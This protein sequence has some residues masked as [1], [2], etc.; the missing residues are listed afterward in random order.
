MLTVSEVA[1]LF[2]SSGSTILLETRRDARDGASR[3]A[4]PSS[5]ALMLTQ[6]N[7]AASRLRAQLGMRKETQGIDAYVAKTGNVVHHRNDETVAVKMR[8]R[9]DVEVT[10]RGRPDGICTSIGAIVEHKYRPCGLLERVPFYEQVQ[11]HLYMKMFGL[12]LAHLVETFNMHMR[13]HEIEFDANTWERI[14]SVLVQKVGASDF[15]VSQKDAIPWKTYFPCAPSTARSERP[16]LA[17]Q[18]SSSRRPT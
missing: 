8:I 18:T 17:E 13:V 3:R 11:C 4:S 5:R 6:S 7:G 10:V 16:R 14:C 2:R 12:K 1:A 15:I 9:G